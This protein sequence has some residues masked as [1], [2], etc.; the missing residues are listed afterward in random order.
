MKVKINNEEY[1]LFTKAI[2]KKVI[3]KFKS[4]DILQDINGNIDFSKY[5]NNQC[6]NS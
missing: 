6:D 5:A 1:E 3:K 4:K 2:S